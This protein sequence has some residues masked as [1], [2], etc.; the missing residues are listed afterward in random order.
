MNHTLTTLI[1]N[2]IGE[3][4][5]GCDLIGLTD[6]HNEA[7]SDLRARVPELTELITKEVR[8]D[9]IDMILAMFP[10]KHPAT[11]KR[12]LKQG[13]YQGCKFVNETAVWRLHNLKQ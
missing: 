10:F 2:W 9:T 5:I 3:D 8:N 6:S 4:K 7:L 11:E 12:E 13:F 1:E